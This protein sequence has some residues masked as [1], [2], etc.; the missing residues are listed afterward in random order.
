MYTSFKCG[1]DHAE[2]EIDPQHTKA[3]RWR[4]LVAK[5][6][7]TGAAKLAGNTQGAVCEGLLEII[8]T[9]E[10]GAS[11]VTV[12]TVAFFCFFFVESCKS[13]GLNMFLF[14]GQAIV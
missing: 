7:M 14:W 6:K 2:T 5:V 1:F 12:L 13:H 3:K 11:K 8:E 9:L 10:V 4:Q